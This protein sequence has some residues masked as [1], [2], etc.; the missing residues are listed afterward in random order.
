MK[1]RLLG[2]V[3]A[4]LMCLQPA[5]ALPQVSGGWKIPF[6]GSNSEPVIQ[7]GTLYIGAFDGSVNAIDPR[8]GKTVWRYQTGEGLTSGPEIIVVP[9]RRFEDAMGAALGHSRGGG[10]NG[11]CRRP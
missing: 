3:A 4:S 5:P 1:A 10:R 9:G 8:S 11:L 6:D 2:L 7:D